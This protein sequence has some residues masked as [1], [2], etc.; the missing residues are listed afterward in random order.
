MKIDD[1]YKWLARDEDGELWAFVNKPEKVKS[2]KMWEDPI[3]LGCEMITENKDGKYSSIKWEDEEPWSLID[4][5]FHIATEGAAKGMADFGKIAITAKDNVNKP[6]HYI[7]IHGL[8]VEE[9][10]QNFIPRYEN[11]YAGH[12]VAS[13]IEYL[14]RA[15][16]KNKLEDIEKAKQ[17]LEQI[18]N[19]EK[20][21]PHE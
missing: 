19:Y 14:L 13:A 7:G 10:L 11:S 8:E 15:P 4:I 20:E 12:R 21:Q 17:N 9:V 1:M 18:L 5:K 6:N 16:L 2:V 3:D